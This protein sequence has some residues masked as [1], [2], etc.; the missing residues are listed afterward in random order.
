MTLN[1][2]RTLLYNKSQ[3]KA[4]IIQFRVTEQDYA[5][6]MPISHRR[7]TNEWI[8]KRLLRRCKRQC[9]EWLEGGVNRVCQKLIG[10]VEL[11]YSRPQQTPRHHSVRSLRD[12]TY[13]KAQSGRRSMT[14]RRR[15]N[16]QKNLCH[17]TIK[18]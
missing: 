3:A 11:K 8:I 4:K 9:S 15:I 2:N 14:L 5:N 1:S 10:N 6:L 16:S 17:V 7:S 18:T 13:Q 12:L